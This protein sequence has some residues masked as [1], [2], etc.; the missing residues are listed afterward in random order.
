MSGSRPQRIVWTLRH[1]TCSVK[2]WSHGPVMTTATLPL[3]TKE[4]IVLAAE[5]LFAGSGRQRPA[6]N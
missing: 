2:R 4:Q 6:F 3:S 5:R 1:L